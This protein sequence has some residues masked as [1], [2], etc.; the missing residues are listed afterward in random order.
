[1]DEL[2][3]SCFKAY[4]ARGR[5]PDELNVEVA[6][7]IGRA[8]AHFVQPARVA[9]GHDVRLTSPTLQEAIARGLT[10]AGV[11]VFDIG[12]CGTEEVYFATF[13]QGL[14]GGIMTTA[15][16]NPMDYNGFKFVRERASPI[17][18][19]TGLQTI[20]VLAERGEFDEP[21][22]RG[23]VR[24]LDHR[25]G[26]IEHLLSYVNPG[27]LP[28]LKIVVNA[29]NGGAGEIID[30]LE[31]HL[32]FEFVKINHVP[33]GHFP[34][35]IPNPLLPERRRATID[36]LIDS[37]ADLGI[38]WDGDFDRCF[39]FDQAGR[40]I[41]GYYIVGLLADHLLAGHPGEAIIHEPRLIWNT[42]EMVEAAGGRPVQS[43]AGHAFLKESMRRENA[44]YGGE[45]SAHHFF[46]DFGFCDSGMIP[47]LVLAEVLGASGKPLSELLDQ[48]I[49]SF[50]V[51]GEIN[52]RVEDAE[53]VIAR[54]REHYARAG[55]EIDTMDGL[56]ITF[57]NWRFNVRPSNTEPVLRLNVESRG[58]R[59]LME[60]RTEEVL[61][62]IGGE[63]A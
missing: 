38:A 51:S 43:K 10:D 57:E 5:V 37:G 53:T 26:Y 52:R 31:P 55:G 14:D 44:L 23:K 9:V 40:F 22:R 49:E 30:L 63:A 27:A 20:R 18:G 62:L 2:Q 12:R 35:G 24:R 58:D 33:D 60:A 36:A 48:R 56:S 39:F 15:S 34:N 47:W 13:S 25:P 8:Y 21:A 42:I 1:M 32:P 7:R 6:Y 28:R 29:G 45:M 19:D 46:R 59:A 17:S 11:D 54:I 3:I 16:H 41:E 61:G 4:D 50:P